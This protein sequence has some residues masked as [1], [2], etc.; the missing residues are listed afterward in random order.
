MKKQMLN[1]VMMAFIS[2]GLTLTNLSNAAERE[3]IDGKQLAHSAFIA[4]QNGAIIKEIGNCDVP[5]SPYSTFKA[6]LAL[7]GFDAGILHDK[8]SPRWSFKEEYEKQFQSWYTRAKGL[9]Y[10]WCQDHTPATFMKHSVIW[11]SHQI[12]KELGAEKFQEYISKKLTYGNG[13][14]SGTP[15]QN[16]GL[17]NSWLGT[18]L[19]ISPREQVA[20]LE[21]LIAHK[22]DLSEDAQKKTKEIMDRA[23]DWNGWKLYG[24]TGG[25]SG[26]DG[27]F[28]GWIEKEEAQPI[29]FAQY[30]DKADSNLDL[31][32]I[33]DQP[34][35]LTAKEVI[36]KE[37]LTFLKKS[38][39]L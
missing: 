20:F 6:V 28:I 16:D 12:T 30:L 3:N 21:K 25:G 34:V 1:F 24:K 32:D 38:T 17:V 29:V 37:M 26:N 14:V 2:T 19:H 33:P 27:W 7:V 4:K 39:V 13:D 8:D 35:G 15:G 31:T 10:G 5:H 22:L 9:Q 18:S 23:E 36:K 11:F